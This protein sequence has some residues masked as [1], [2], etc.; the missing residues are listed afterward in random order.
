[1]ASGGRL[2]LSSGRHNLIRRGGREIGRGAGKGAKM[3]AARGKS[4]ARAREL[5][6]TR[7]KS[8]AWAITARG[9][10]GDW[11]RKREGGGRTSCSASLL[12]RSPARVHRQASTEKKLPPL[13]SSSP[14]Q[15]LPPVMRCRLW[16]APAYSASV[17]IVM[18]RMPAALL[19]I[20]ILYASFSCSAID[21]N[22]NIVCS[23][24]MPV[25]ASSL[26]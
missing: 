17:N 6:P 23:C 9:A 19:L 5:R 3:T 7:G 26:L 13:A 4:T 18:P 15:H 24:W 16:Y 20:W 1:M 11:E 21:L 22:R 2:E 25:P 14:L 12:L 10:R 8:T